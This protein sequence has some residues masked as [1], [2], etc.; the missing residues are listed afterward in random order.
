MFIV[1]G[2]K[3]YCVLNCTSAISYL[4]RKTYIKQ[5]KTKSVT[6]KPCSPVLA[7]PGLKFCAI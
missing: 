3:F 2:A 6:Q 5:E 7:S 4:S 1:K